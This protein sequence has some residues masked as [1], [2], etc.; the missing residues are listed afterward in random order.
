MP[1]PILVSTWPFGLPANNAGFV[2]AA[3]AGGLLDALEQTCVHCELDPAVDSVGIGGIPDS[4]GVVSLDGAVMLS[5]ARSAGV[6]YVRKYAHPVSI[7]RRVME[8]TPHKLLVGEGAEAFAAGEGFKTAEL[9]TDA[10]RKKWETW[11]ASGAH[12]DF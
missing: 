7:A 9:L 4:S 3:R 8:K 2:H 5:P 10:A 1:E 12:L 11:K 6:G